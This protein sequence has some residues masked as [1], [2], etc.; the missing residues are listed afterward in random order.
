ME[1]EEISKVEI[2][3]NQEM[4]VVLASGGKPMYQYIYR[5]A[6]EVYWD[7]DIKGFKAPPPRKTLGVSSNIPTFVRFTKHEL[8]S[9]GSVLASLH[10]KSTHAG[11]HV[12]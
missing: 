3:D 11:D 1:I 10:C 5:E 6:A 8:G 9:V 7:N 2:L 12:R 4:Y